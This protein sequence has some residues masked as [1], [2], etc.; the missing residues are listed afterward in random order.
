[1][2]DDHDRVKVDISCAGDRPQIEIE[3]RDD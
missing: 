3:D 2:S 1:V